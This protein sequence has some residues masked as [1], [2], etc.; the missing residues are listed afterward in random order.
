VHLYG[1][2][3]VFYTSLGHREDIWRDPVFQSVLHGGIDWALHRFD[4]DITPNLG[5]VA[6]QAN[7]LPAYVPPP[8]SRRKSLSEETRRRSGTARAT[9]EAWNPNTMTPPAGPPPSK[10]RYQVAALTYLL[11]MIVYL[12]RV[13]LATSRP[14]SWRSSR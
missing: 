11:A 2:G 1:K 5:E 3:R 13:C 8:P 6:P 9:P 14:R 4:A 10:V 12:D 7:A